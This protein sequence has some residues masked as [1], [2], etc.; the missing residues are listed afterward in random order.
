MNKGVLIL[1]F[2]LFLSL[3]SAAH[4]AEDCS[5][6]EIEATWDSIFREP[7]TGI[8]IFTNNNIEDNRCDK[9]FA[10]K[11]SGNYVFFLRTDHNYPNE[12]QTNIEAAR[13]NATFSFLNILTN[14]TNISQVN[15]ERGYSLIEDNTNQRNPVLPNT[16]ISE[17]FESIFKDSSLDWEIQE[18]DVSGSNTNLYS[19][20]KI[21]NNSDYNITEK[22]NI[23]KEYDY[24]SLN[25]LY[26]PLPQA[27][28]INCT[29]NWSCN[30]WSD[31]INDNQTRNCADL[32]N[33]ENNKTETRPCACDVSW[34]CT[35]WSDCIGNQQI[36]FCYD[37]NSC[38][39]ETNKPLESQ[40]CGTTCT[41][42]WNCSEWYPKGCTEEK[43]QLRD[44][45]DLNQCNNSVGRP[46]EIQPCEKSYA[47]LVIFIIIIVV[48]LIIG[49][50]GIL[51]ERY[52]KKNQG[53]TGTPPINPPYKPFPRTPPSSPTQKPIIKKPI[54]PNLQRPIQKTMFP[55]KPTPTLTKPNTS[56]QNYI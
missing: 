38:G 37:I 42:N 28:I 11:I 19:Y 18:I 12:N 26:D 31:C 41:P 30:E 39:N 52:N 17:K 36:R 15:F 45:F 47:W 23:A 40:S 10:Y 2:I 21:R 32:N 51:K 1:F 13:L 14:I 53:Y 20:M 55:K 33:C 6:S 3:A 54:N 35:E 8:T 44:C 56:K 22:G 48:I 16:S 49:T 34:N 46:D 25:Y 27:Q 50:I 5:T 9:F 29:S 7:T 24:A 4:P 43:T